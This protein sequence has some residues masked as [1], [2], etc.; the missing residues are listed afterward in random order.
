[1]IASAIVPAVGANWQRPYA[2]S[3]WSEPEILDGTATE[4]APALATF[5][6]QLYLPRRM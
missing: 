1:M 3:G 2:S 6:G 4:D 5:E